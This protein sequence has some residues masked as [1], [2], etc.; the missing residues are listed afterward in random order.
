MWIPAYFKNMFLGGIMR[1]TS[2][3]ESENS[4]YGDFMNSKISLV[5]FW[6]RFESAI[7]AQRQKELPADNDSLYSLPI[8]KLDHGLEKHGREV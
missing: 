3:S 8:L 4:F 5:A 2:V 1:T 6:M 7:E